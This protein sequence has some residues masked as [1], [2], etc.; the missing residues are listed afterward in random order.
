[1]TYMGIKY[2]SQNK[3]QIQVPIPLY[4]GSNSSV[5]LMICGPPV[6]EQLRK[7]NRLPGS[8]DQ[9][10]EEASYLCEKVHGLFNQ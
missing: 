5:T 2:T 1:M 6:N 7:N 4:H 8:I 3:V 10:S 9:V